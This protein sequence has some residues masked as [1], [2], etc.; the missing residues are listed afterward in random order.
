MSVSNPSSFTVPAAA[1]HARLRAVKLVCVSF[2]ATV[3][4]GLAGERVSVIVELWEGS[5]A[6]PRVRLQFAVI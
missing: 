5:P 6:G 2:A 1:V 3:E 4:E